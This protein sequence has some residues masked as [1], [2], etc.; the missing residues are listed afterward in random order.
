MHIAVVVFTTGTEFLQ[1]KFT[2]NKSSSDEDNGG[3]SLVG[4]RGTVATF[5]VSKELDQNAGDIRSQAS[6]SPLKSC[7]NPVGRVRFSPASL[8]TIKRG[9]IEK[10]NQKNKGGN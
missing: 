7:G 9:K 4:E 3:C 5:G 8:R 2:S 6:L 1:G 10:N